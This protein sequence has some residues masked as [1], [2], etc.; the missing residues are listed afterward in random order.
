MTLTSS[1]A[2]PT[3]RASR[4]VFRPRVEALESREVLSTLL[5]VQPGDPSSFNTIQA[6]VNAAHAGDKIEIFGGTYAEAV[7]VS[8]PGISLFGA[9]GA[10]VVITNPGGA[11][12]GITVQLAGGGTLAGFNLA[13]VT[14]SGFAG[15]GVYLSNVN[16][17]SLTNVTAQGNGEYGLFPV[18]SANG[19]IRN[20]TASGSNDTGIYVGQSKNVVVSYSLAFNNV[21]GIELENCTACTAVANVVYDNTV[22]IL[23]DLLPGLTVQ[24]ATGNIIQANYVSANNKPN[25][26]PAGDLAALEPPGTGIAVVGGTGTLVQGNVVTANGY[27]GIAVL[28]GADLLGAYPKG[29]DP[30]PE[31]TTVYNNLALGNGFVPAVPAG[32]PKAADLLWDGSGL[33]N[34][35]QHNQY[36]TST[37][38]HLP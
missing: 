24:T 22:G 35:W 1:F 20:C 3:R 26:A 10:H 38:G 8:K 11:T 4:S 25:T 27:A 7:T 6:A 28:S 12:N 30:N 29:L 19:Q 15:D 2:L 21:N 17:F 33:N 34:H 16:G 31:N 18:L 14:V 5:I 36:Q 37:P 13:N 9:T 23:E 32:F